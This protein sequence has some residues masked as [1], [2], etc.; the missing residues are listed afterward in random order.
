MTPAS[1]YQLA[2]IFIGANVVALGSG[3]PYMY[4]F[5][6][7][8]LLK[9]CHLDIERSSDFSFAMSL[10]M[11]AMGVFAGMIIDH[12]PSLATGIGAFLTF[13]AYSTLYFC[14]TYEYSSV[15]LIFVALVMIGFGSICSF[16]AA[17]KCCTANFPN[18]RGAAGAFPISQYALSGLVFSLLCSSLFKDDIQSVFLFLIIVCTSTAL[19]GCMTFRIIEEDHVHKVE[20]SEDALLAL[21]DSGAENE[22]PSLLDETYH[23][24]PINVINAKRGSMSSVTYNA[25]ATG[26][27]DSSS[28]T[29]AAMKQSS[30]TTLFSL[31]RS[32]SVSSWTKDL[33]GSLQFWGIG[34]ARPSDSA[35]F[36]Y[37]PKRNARTSFTI[38]VNPTQRRQSLS[39]DQSQNSTVLA[40]NNFPEPNIDNVSHEINI[41]TSKIETI[42]TENKQSWWNE[43]PVLKNLSKPR[44]FAYL[45]TLATLQGIGQMY[46]FAVG[47]VVTTQIQSSDD[48]SSWNQEEYLSLQVS[49]ISVMSFGARF[50]SGIV[51]DLLVKKF[52]SQRLWII[53]FSAVLSIIASRKLISLDPDTSTTSSNLHNISLSSVL[54]GFAFGMAFGTFPAIIAD[55]F[56]TKGFST[57]WGLSTAGGIF[58]VKILSGILANDLSVHMA[59]NETTCTKG[60]KCYS[61]TFHITQYWGLFAVFLSLLTIFISYRQKIE[62]HR[63]IFTLDA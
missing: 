35:L 62:R 20:S 46:I 57:L 24:K 22:S 16:Y 31:R 27:A 6:A 29:A 51:S 19:I 30:S 56:G 37:H 17:M 63:A 7:P 50:L 44:F 55:S 2:S 34:R 28:P 4:S 38:D 5:Y 21:D 42:S 15:F 52:H 32:D 36:P 25:F 54:F 59:P 9:K 58:T 43:H 3:T 60:I 23:S 13:F 48:P 61:H 49:L 12:S 33:V 8:Q 10:G 47:F 53:T 40:S 1:K 18:H 41:Q 14:Y 39:Q 26:S 45:F 11:S